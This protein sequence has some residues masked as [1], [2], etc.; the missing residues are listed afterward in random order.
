MKRL[1]E[2]DRL[3]ILLIIVAQLAL[4]ALAIQRRHGQYLLG[5]NYFYETPAWNLASGHGLSME[6]SIA[7][8]PWLTLSYRATHP[9]SAGSVYV[10]S[11]TYAP[12]YTVFLAGVYVLAGHHHLAAVLANLGLLIV[13]LILCWQIVKKMCTSPVEKLVAAGLMAVFPGWAFWVSAILS[14][15]LNATLIA[16]FAVLFFTET[17]TRKRA[18]LAGL[19]LGAAIL[20]RPYPTLLPIGLFVGWLVRKVP[21]FAPR[22]LIPMSLVAWACL[23]TWTVRN[24]IAYGKLVPVTSMGLGRGLWQTT[25]SAGLFEDVS[26]DPEFQRDDHVL[27]AAVGDWHY[28][29]A[30]AAFQKAAMERIKAQPVRWLGM[31]SWRVVRL[32]ISAV[33]DGAPRIVLLGFGLLQ[34]VMLLALVAGIFVAWQDQRAM[35]AGAIVLV[36]FHWALFVPFGAEGRLLLAVR[37]FSIA[38]GAMAAGA[39]YRRWR[40]IAPVEP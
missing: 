40:G 22:Y 21:A 39:L 12:G 15:M 3:L 2:N 29:D 16:G 17:P 8:D 38:L 5:D 11:T 31:A 35:V 9:E 27:G 6:T 4:S 7:D 23:G 37:V 14:D 20:V 34:V 26:K 19:V 36:V 18:L 32:W 33:A 30:S 25:Y 24:Q 1:A 13:F 10:P 28:H